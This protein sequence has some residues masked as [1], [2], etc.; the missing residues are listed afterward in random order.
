MSPSLKPKL[1]RHKPSCWRD[2]RRWLTFSN[3]NWA[4]DDWHLASGNAWWRNSGDQFKACKKIRW[5]QHSFQIWKLVYI[6]CRKYHELLESTL[7]IY[8]LY[9]Y[10][11]G[12]INFV[13]FT[14]FGNSLWEH[15]A[16]LKF[17]PLTYDIYV[18][19]NMK[20]MRFQLWFPNGCKSEQSIC[21]PSFLTHIHKV[22]L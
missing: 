16:A 2:E 6:S 19:F 9:F 5:I 22:Q 11:T 17:C 13:H 21:I 10:N 7:N 14:S 8:R 18:S 3:M 12:S 1:L 4:E 20:F 15:N